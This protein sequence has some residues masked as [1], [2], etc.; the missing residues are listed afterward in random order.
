VEERSM[1]DVEFER[2]ARLSREQA[3]KHLIA[4]GRALAAGRTAEV[5]EEGVSVRFAVADEVEWEFELEVDG[6]EVELEIELKW[7]DRPPARAAA[8]APARPRKAAARP[9]KTARKR[10]G[11]TRRAGGA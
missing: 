3:G 8:S 10:S 9:A 2:K 11:T 4:L 7:S 5:D 1:A 6:D